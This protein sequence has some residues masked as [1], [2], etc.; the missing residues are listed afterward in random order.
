M[1][2]TCWHIGHNI[3]GY[4]P[5]SDV[6]CFLDR[7]EAAEAL[8]DEMRD[9]A[10]RDDDDAWEALA[11][12]PVSDYPTDEEGNPDYGD[13]TPSMLATVAAILTDD[14]P[15]RWAAVDN[16][17]WSGWAEDGSGR[18]V[19]FWLAPV[20]GCDHVECEHERD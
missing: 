14:G 12:V 1:G 11:D 17:E 9:Y 4:L 16:G 5:E 2:A 20:T 18:H 8:D 7:S 19:V 13:D 6:S 10:D 3:A 15:E